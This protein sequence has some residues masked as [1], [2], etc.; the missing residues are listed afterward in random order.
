MTTRPLTFEDAYRQLDDAMPI[1][2]PKLADLAA[3]QADELRA[4]ALGHAQDVLDD[5]DRTMRDNP[6]LFIGAATGFALALG[7]LLSRRGV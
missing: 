5:V 2:A 6:A 3:V 1:E 4:L 7:V